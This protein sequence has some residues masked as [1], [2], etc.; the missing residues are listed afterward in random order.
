[1][2]ECFFQVGSTWYKSHGAGRGTSPMLSDR[3]GVGHSG[4]RA[5]P[6]CRK[7]CPVSHALNE[8]HLPVVSHENY[9]YAPVWNSKQHP[10]LF[11][12]SP[13]A[14]TSKGVI[15]QTPRCCWWQETITGTEIP[16]GPVENH[17]QLSNDSQT[18]LTSCHRS[19]QGQAQPQSP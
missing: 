19:S 16:E 14:L 2:P 13:A 9:I 7:S 10:H 4:C 17:R 1:M 12:L 18:T 3:P 5:E 6:L 8:A 15:C 11:L